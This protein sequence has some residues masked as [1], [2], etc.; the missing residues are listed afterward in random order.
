MRVITALLMALGAALAFTSSPVRAASNGGDLLAACTSAP[1]TP[2]DSF[3]N[4]YINGFVQGIYVDQIIREEGGSLC[5]DTT[6]TG[7]VR[8]ALTEFL[9][10]H[11]NATFLPAGSVLGAAVHEQYRCKSH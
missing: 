4:A 6:N 5:M 7:A 1:G 10:T 3:C 2:G 8:A 9:R 11:A